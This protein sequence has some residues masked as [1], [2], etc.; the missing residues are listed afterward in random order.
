MKNEKLLKVSSSPHVHSGNSIPA[1]M[2]DVIIALLPATAVALYLFGLTALAVIATSV[3]TAVLAEYVCQ[4]LRGVEI[5]ITDYSAAVTGLLFAL[6]IPPATPLWLTFIGATVC[7]V[8]GKQVF[9]GLGNNLFNPALVGRALLVASWPVYMTSF[10]SPFDGVSSATPLGIIGAINK[11]AAAGLT[12]DPELMSSLP[13]L[14]NVFLGNIAGSMG[15]TSALAL[16]IGGL[17]LIFKKHIDWKIPTLYVGTVFILAL[18]FAGPYPR[19]WYAFYNVFAGGLLI[20]A[21]FMA[22]DWVTSPTTKKGRIIY[23]ICLGLLTFIIRKGAGL[24]EG[25]AYSIVIMNMVT[26]LID[27]YSRGRV[28]GEVKKHG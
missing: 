25:V 17:Y 19:L 26:P 3:A 6:V 5:T 27:R 23:G 9:G 13:S 18:I 14:S 20:G 22:T 11:Q 15:E 16:L 28:F 2:R 24:P 12:I 21:F 8:I 1:A 4:K 7:I 10:T